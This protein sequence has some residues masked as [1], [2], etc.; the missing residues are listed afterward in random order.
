MSDLK[1]AVEMMDIGPTKRGGKNKLFLIISGCAL[2][3]ALAV[4][5]VLLLTGGSAEDPSER[6]VEFGTVMQGVSVG[7]IDISGMTKG[8]ALAATADLSNQLLSQVNFDVDI[9]GEVMTFTAQEF[10]L[11][12]DYE[13]VMEQ[14]IAYGRTGTF[15][16][17]LAAA[18][19]AKESSVDFPV[20]ILVDEAG[21]K[22]ALAS[23]KGEMDTPP[24]DAA[25]DFA[26]W[27]YSETQNADGT[28]TYT[29]YTPELAT[30]IDI[31]TA[32]SKG[33]AYTGFPADLVRIADEEMPIPLRYQY[34][35]NDHYEKDYR[36][37]DANIARFIYTEEVDGLVV[38]TDAIYDAVIAQVESDTYET[39]VAPVESTPATVKLADIRNR[40]QLISSWTSSYSDH[41]GTARNYNVAMLSSLLTG[42]EIEP[43]E[44]WSIN[45]T[46]GPRN[47]TTAK[48]YGWREAAGIEN[49]GY[50]PQYGGGVCQLGST[51]FNAAIRSGLTW[52]EHWHHS[53]PSGYVPLGLDSTLDSPR[54]SS[55][56]GKDLKLQNDTANTFYLVSY[57]NPLDKN[58]TVEIYGVPLTDATGQQII[59]NYSFKNLGRYGS[60]KA[61]EV[62]VSEGFV[63]P[64]GTVISATGLTS[65]EFAK[66]SAGTIVQT[67]QITL[68]LDGT[69]IGDPVEYE[70]HR[71]PV[72]N[73]TTYRLIVPETPPVVTDPAVVTTDTT[74]P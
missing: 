22:A 49:G 21:L 46:A 29:K 24:I 12:T 27:G 28:V 62:P 57:V 63:C 61:S 31:C 1:N 19:A 14:A 44:I 55:Y 73:G 53:I 37:V 3:V 56:A 41:Y 30:L 23:F 66:S 32:Y 64:D 47:A 74:V 54:G 8:E 38:D 2:V 42:A 26:P 39:F 7:G 50:T 34:W 43:G 6:V 69:Q 45:D 9:N 70:Y 10:A 68:A 52:T 17:R 72:I 71:Y 15:D 58:V 33:K 65:Y 59:L 48:T 11:Y 51:T 20:D 5:A 60:P 4:C 40:T 25:A 13:T 36:P 18:N 16:E 35:E 67:Y